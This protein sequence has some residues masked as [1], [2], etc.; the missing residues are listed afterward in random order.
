[1]DYLK[2][3]W[4][5][6]KHS[7][8]VDYLTWKLLLID[9]G[10]IFT[11]ILSYS[12]LYALWIKN[13]F[14]LQNI[15]DVAQTG[16]VLDVMPGLS[17]TQL[18]DK[19]IFNLILIGV[20]AVLIY[21]ILISIYGAISHKFISKK[22]FSLKLLLNF[23]CVN[24][25]LTVVYVSLIISIYYLSNEIKLIAW[26]IVIFTLLYFYAL[27]IFYLVT[28]NDKLSKIFMHGL[29]SM[30][31]LHYTLIPMILSI[32]LFSVYLTIIYF[33]S[34]GNTVILALLGIVGLFYILVWTKR[35]LH[36]VIHD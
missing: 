34:F 8:N 31:K 30:I 36:H 23:L 28:K 6:L 13:L 4:N 16:Q 21:I 10:F 19:L 9:L 32:I 14:S 20:L 15:I 22:E 7:F 24:T 29:K 1:M 27:L 12:I 33:L 17:I 26:S 35:Y 25:I 2:K 18:W 5:I 3:H 11:L